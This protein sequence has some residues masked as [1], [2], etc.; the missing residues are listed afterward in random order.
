MEIKVQK[1]PFLKA[2]NL[3]GNVTSSKTT[4]IP[5]LGNLLIETKDKS[6]PADSIFV[7][8]R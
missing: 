3:V 8:K 4:A 5:I 1:S 6:E 2:I 7:L